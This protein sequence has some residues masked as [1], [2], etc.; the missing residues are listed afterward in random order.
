MSSYSSLAQYRLFSGT[1]LVHFLRHL[2]SFIFS[3]TFL[4]YIFSGTFLFIFFSGTFLLIFSQVPSS[5]IFSRIFPYFLRY[6]LVFF[7]GIIFF[8]C[9][10]YLLVFFLRYFFFSGIFFFLR[11]LP[12]SFSPVPSFIIFSGTFLF[13]F[14]P[15]V[16]PD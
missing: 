13:Y 6:L 14:R 16:V 1:F 7:F 15:S 5:F 9:L 12:F 2:P 4:F 8:Y 3:G 11:Y 10:R